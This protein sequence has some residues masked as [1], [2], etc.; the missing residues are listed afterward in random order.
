MNLIFSV[1]FLCLLRFLHSE[2]SLL[3]IMDGQIKLDLLLFILSFHSCIL[4]FFPLIL[5]VFFIRRIPLHMLSAHGTQGT[6]E[7]PR[8]YLRLQHDTLVRLFANTAVMV[9]H[10]LISGGCCSAKKGIKFQRSG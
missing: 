1:L 4:S 6:N 7:S 2:I 10:L 3:V 5:V 9:Y 8:S